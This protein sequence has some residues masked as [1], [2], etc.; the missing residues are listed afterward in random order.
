MNE[1]CGFEDFANATQWKNENSYS[2]IKSDT[3]SQ[4]RKNYTFAHFFFKYHK[5]AYKNVSP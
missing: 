4:E 1:E 3:H 2:C 5:W